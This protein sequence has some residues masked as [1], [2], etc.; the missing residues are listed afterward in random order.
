MRSSMSNDEIPRDIYG[1]PV[2]PTNSVAKRLNGARV[3]EVVDADK[4]LQTQRASQRSK[5]RPVLPT[6]QGQN[7]KSMSRQ[8][9]LPNS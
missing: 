3:R 5:Q 7:R 6:E 2:S 1:R 4:T 8:G 9:R